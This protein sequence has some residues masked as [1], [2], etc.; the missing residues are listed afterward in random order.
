MRKVV[1]TT[2]LTSQAAVIKGSKRTEAVKEYYFSHKLKEI[3]QMR[4][5]GIDVINLGIGSPDLAPSNSAIDVLES[6]AHNANCHGYQSYAGVKELREAFSKWY[7]NY[8]DTELDASNEILPLMGS[9]E[10]IMH[11]SMAFV[12]PAEQ[13]LVPNPGYPAYAAITNLVGGEVVN[14]NLT[15]ENNWYPNIEELEKRDLSKVKL[16]WINYPNMPTGQ[17]ASKEVFKQLVAFAKRHNILLCNDN[18]YSFILNNQHISLLSIEGA[19]EVALELNS[20]SKSHNMSGW[21]IGMVAGHK[22][23]I[24]AIIKVKS[25]IDSGMF[26]PLQM[27]AASALSCGDEWYEQINR[28]YSKRRVIAET[29][30]EQLGCS[31]DVAQKGMFLW[32]EIPSKYKNSEELANDVLYNSHVFIA[33]GS[34]FGSRGKRYIRVSLC[35][36]EEILSEAYSRVSKLN[37]GVLKESVKEFVV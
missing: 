33:P 30:M 16:M 3:E 20:I 21:R 11:I 37:L 27:A 4:E 19:K 35:A 8:F 6:Y 25:N 9:K 22:E 28:V 34:I 24:K 18:P 2:N 23:Y 29:L 1:N 15:P 17:K 7:H 32:G 31:F 12:N 26:K 36:S 14:Y 10:G 13:V 5:L